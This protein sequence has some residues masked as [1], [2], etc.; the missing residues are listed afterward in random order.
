M[1]E[2]AIE[3]K[4]LTPIEPELA[5]IDAVRNL[6]GLH[7]AISRLQSRGVN[8]LF[9][10]GSEEDRKDSSRVIAAAIQAGLGLPERDYYLKTD[11]KS[12]ELRRK[13]LVHVA[14]MLKLAGAVP[15]KAAADAKS[16]LDL[17]TRLAQASMNNVDLRDPDKT[18]HPMTLAALS[19]AMPNL[20]WA[21][22]HRDQ[23]VAAEVPVNVWTPDFFRAEDALL[24]SVPIATWKAYL[25]WHLLSATAATLPSRFVDEDFALKGKTLAGV[26]EIQPR[27]KRCVNATDDAMGMALGRIYVR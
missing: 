5:K 26:P 7:T 25:P 19:K 3:R 23:S 16:I 1:D 10:F 24:R 15:R 13:Y 6:P 22:F 11:A 12:V 14:R 2:A 21:E 17:E 4:G 18:H 20:G 27:W 9:A 8:V